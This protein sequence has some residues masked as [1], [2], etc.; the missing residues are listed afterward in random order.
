MNQFDLFRLQQGC[1]GKSLENEKVR[2]KSGN[3]G[4][5][6]GNWEKNKMTK[7]REK[8]GNLKKFLKTE[9]ALAVSLIFT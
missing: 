6:Q 1:Q 8:S 3:F 7:V 2:A 5:S 4:L 9:T